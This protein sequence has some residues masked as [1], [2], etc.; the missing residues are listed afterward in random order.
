[1]ANDIHDPFVLAIYDTKSEYFI[2]YYYYYYYYW[3]DQVPGTQ[4]TDCIVPVVLARKILSVVPV[5]S[6]IVGTNYS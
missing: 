3:L 5:V 4:T 2:E 6:R 1:M